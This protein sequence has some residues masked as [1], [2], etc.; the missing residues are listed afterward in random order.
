MTYIYAHLHSKVA[1]RSLIK[2]RVKFMAI[3]YNPSL[4]SC[5]KVYKYIFKDCVTRIK[6]EIVG[7]KD[8]EIE[9]YWNLGMIPKCL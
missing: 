1:D 8:C 7:L 6:K 9:G 4:I 3:K 2:T 5:N